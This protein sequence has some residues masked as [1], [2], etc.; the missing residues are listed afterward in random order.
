MM[1]RQSGM[2]DTLRLAMDRGTV[3]SFDEFGRLRVAVSNISKANVCPYY[4]RDIPDSETLGLDAN[5]IYMLLRDP[6]EL[7][8]AAPTFNSLP[9]LTEHRPHT[10]H[11][12]Q[13]SITAGTTGGDAHF[14]APY[15][16]NSLVIWDADAIALIESEEQKELSA[17][18]AYKA[19]M[20]PGNYE[21]QRYDGVMRQI[22]GNHIALVRSGRAGR[23][24]VVGDSALEPRPKETSMKV[25]P[26]DRLLSSAANLAAIKQS[27][28]LAQ[29]ADV[30]D[31]LL[32]LN[33]LDGD[34]PDGDEPGMVD[35]DMLDDDMVGDAPPDTD[36]AKVG[37]MP[38][39]A[40][41]DSDNDGEPDVTDPDDTT[42]QPVADEPVDKALNFLKDLIRPE[43]LAMV[44]HILKPAAPPAAADPKP[45]MVAGTD[46]PKPFP[47]MPKPGG[48]MDAA[49]TKV[50]MDEAMARVAKETRLATIRQMRGIA[51]AED[52]VRPWV[53]KLV[54]AQDSAEAVYKVALDTLGIDTKGVHASAYRHILLAQPKPGDEPRGRRIA[55][56]AAPKAGQGFEDRFPNLPAQRSI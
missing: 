16:Q 27:G 21:G 50:A 3:R 18:Y 30:Q 15:L 14:S 41:V 9:I 24:V 13:K 17:G 32:L 29:D 31:L 7:A 8:K 52:A 49:I 11:D 2:T 56:D 43:D 38:P 1:Y 19:D 36:N 39:E 48:A 20:S 12:S 54:I 45:P 42:D 53:G 55:Q 5:R 46:G 28:L 34:E 33:K 40:M 4:G 23:D 47:G 44:Q 51:Q 26:K 6:A 10:A 37:D 25:K 22:R 35:P